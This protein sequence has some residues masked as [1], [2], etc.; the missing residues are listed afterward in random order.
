VVVA[1]VAVLTG[2]EGLAGVLALVIGGLA[3]DTALLVFSSGTFVSEGVV[4]GCFLTACGIREEPEVVLVR[5]EEV[6]L[7][8]LVADGVGI[9]LG[10]VALAVAA[11]G[12]WGA[13]PLGFTVA[14]V[15][16]TFGLS[17]PT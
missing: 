15:F 4:F 5:A 9:L 13:M 8:C 1:G 7:G 10:V 6:E 16:L 2:A 11:F 17:I 3:V 12:L 14:V